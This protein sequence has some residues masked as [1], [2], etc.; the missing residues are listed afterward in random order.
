MNPAEVVE[1]ALEMAKQREKECPSL[2]MYNSI[3]QQLEFLSNYL[4]GNDTDR[5]KLMNLMFGVY[6]AKELEETDP[7]FANILGKAFY[8][9]SQKKKGLRVDESSLNE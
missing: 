1:K 5:T 4:A 7:D 9:A 2:P 3:V 8:V 6:A